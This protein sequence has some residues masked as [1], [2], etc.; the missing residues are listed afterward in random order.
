MERWGV[1]V[2]TLLEAVQRLIQPGE[3]KRRLCPVTMMGNLVLMTP[4]GRSLSSTRCYESLPTPLQGFL[5]TNSLPGPQPLLRQLPPLPSHSIRDTTR[6]SMPS[7]SVSTLPPPWS[8]RGKMEWLG[9]T[10]PPPSLPITTLIPHTPG[11]NGTH[12]HT[13]THPTL[14]SAHPL[15]SSLEFSPQDCYC[16]TC[17]GALSTVCIAGHLDPVC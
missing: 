8:E 15:C 5:L 12:T 10:T 1:G 11:G 16:S 3:G 17:C 9:G 2:R 7:P 4:M 6:R 14:T 13:L